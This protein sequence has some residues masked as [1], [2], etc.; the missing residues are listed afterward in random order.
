LNE[1]E[2]DIFRAD[3]SKIQQEQVNHMYLGLFLELIFQKF[4]TTT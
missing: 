2:V 1:E 4:K 3:F